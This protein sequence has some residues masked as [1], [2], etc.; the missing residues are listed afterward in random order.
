MTSP[1]RHLHHHP[2]PHAQ[3]NTMPPG[4][5]R[6]V[7]TLALLL[8]A[9][10]AMWLCVHWLHWP[11]AAQ[12][13]MAGLPSPW[14]AGLMRLHGGAMML[15]LIVAGRVSATHAQRGWRVGQR[16]R[17]GV[18]ML[19]SLALLALTG[20]ALFYWVPEDLRD[21]VG[22]VHGGLGLVW[23]FSLLWHRRPVPS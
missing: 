9:S 17:G 4:Q 19:L 3:R 16:R 23:A 14:E 12:A 20:Y 15:M 11:A 18:W 2:N 13:A 1:H 21:Q 10:G 8:A 22:L 7:L 6:L 5:A